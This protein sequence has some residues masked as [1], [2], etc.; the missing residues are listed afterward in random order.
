MRDKLTETLA[1]VVRG[2]SPACPFCGAAFQGTQVYEDEILS[3][4]IRTQVAR[5]SWYCGTHAEGT[6]WDRSSP[7][8][9][10]TVNALRAALHN[11]GYL[12][13]QVADWADRLS[14]GDDVRLDECLKFDGECS[15]VAQKW[16]LGADVGDDPFGTGK[17]DV[18][19]R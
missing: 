13:A 9:Q 18:C 3:P 17:E 4:E 11:V 7:C 6:S 14:D 16:W 2:E 5:H 10:H 1:A 15:A 12:C 19:Q 8:W